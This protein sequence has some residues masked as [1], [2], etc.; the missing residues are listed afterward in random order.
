MNF[1]K[2]NH[3]HSFSGIEP[4]NV[5][6]KYGITLNNKFNGIYY[7]EVKN[8]S[9]FIGA[10]DIIPERY[11]ADFF[12]VELIATSILPAH[13]DSDIKAT[14]NF[15]INTGNY[16]TKFYRIK[17]S[18]NRRF[19]IATQTTGSIF[20]E[21]QLEMIEAFDA[22]PGDIYLL[23][24]NTPHSVVDNQNTDY[25]ITRTALSL[26]THIHDFNAVMEMLKETNSI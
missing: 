12:I 23:N 13:T 19:R 10:F 6:V 9:E 5:K 2:L 26:Q 24:V 7:S 8:K 21:H 17:D 20:F 18:E 15:Y 4:G 3:Q 11:R 1:I 14:I 16:T 25:S 22:D